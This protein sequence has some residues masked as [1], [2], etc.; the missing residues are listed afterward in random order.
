MYVPIY[1][2]YWNTANMSINLEQSHEL[3]HRRTIYSNT[4][5]MMLRVE[6]FIHTFY[7]TVK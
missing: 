1:G 3:H 2:R 6:G 5:I 4:G 7:T